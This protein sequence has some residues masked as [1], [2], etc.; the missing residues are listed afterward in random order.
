MTTIWLKR[1]R[2][3]CHL[4][5]VKSNQLKIRGKDKTESKDSQ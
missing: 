1:Q 3:E 2:K 4:E 5:K